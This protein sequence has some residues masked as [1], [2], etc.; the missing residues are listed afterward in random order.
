VES[1]VSAADG[2]PVAGTASRT[3]PVSISVRGTATAQIAI[4][5][6]HRV[7]QGASHQLAVVL[8]NFGDQGAQ[9]SGNVRVAGDRPQT[10]PFHAD[11]PP[12]RDTTVDLMWNAPPAGSASDIAVDLEYGE[13]NVASWSSRLGGAPTDLSTQSGAPKSTPTTTLLATD[14]SPADGSSLVSEPWWKQSWALV[15]AAVAVLG[16][17]SWIGFE[18]RASRRMRS[19]V[20]P[21][22]ERYGAPAARAQPP[23]DDSI[24]LAK[25]LV[26]LTE[27]IVELVAVHREGWEVSDDRVRARS[28]GLRAPNPE[29]DDLQPARAGPTPPAVEA[30]AQPPVPRAEPIASHRSQ[31]PTAGDP[32]RP[33]PGPEDAIEARFLEDADDEEHDDGAAVSADRAAVSDDAVP[34]DASSTLI[35]RLV[36]LD[37]ERRRLREWMDAED[38]GHAIEPPALPDDAAQR[39][40]RAPGDNS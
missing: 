6:V 17:V 19:G 12:R 32:A 26:R 2:S 5:D 34:A 3:F 16:A 9:V 31:S 13:G 23:N 10:L 1:A 8:R 38:S 14:P 37:R 20:V 40:G 21:A 27:V 18:M 35:Q 11:L 39:A 7:D 30:R 25:Q 22:V 28:P 4:T 36:E 33:E 15:L 29:R 24:D